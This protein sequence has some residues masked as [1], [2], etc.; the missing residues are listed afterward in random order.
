MPRDATLGQ[1]ERDRVIKI[2]HDAL[3][4]KHLHER[5]LTRLSRRS[6]WV[7]YLA[8]AV[9]ILY[10]PVRITANSPT[11]R[12]VTQTLWEFIAAALLVV[13]FTKIS[14]RWEARIRDHGRLRDENLRLANEAAQ[15]LDGSRVTVLSHILSIEPMLEAADTEALGDITKQEKQEAYRA[16]LLE[17]DREG[18]EITCPICNSSPRRFTPGSCPECGNTPITRY[19]GK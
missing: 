14:F 11:L 2:R 8:I 13:A 6:D 19:Q 5:R 15:L 12:M 18:A 10:I 9:P 17:Y 1:A 4:A 16:A 7:D 3:L